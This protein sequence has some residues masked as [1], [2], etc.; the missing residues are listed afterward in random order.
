M[1]IKIRTGKVKMMKMMA[2]GMVSIKKMK[3]ETKIRII[4]NMMMV[5]GNCKQENDDGVGNSNDTKHDDNTNTEQMV[6]KMADT[7]KINLVTPMI[8]KVI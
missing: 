8:L 7:T 3:R 1:K 4:M 5:D 6:I 2:T